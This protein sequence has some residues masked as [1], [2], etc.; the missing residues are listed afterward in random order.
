M[1]LKS[2]CQLKVLYKVKHKDNA[3]LIF[4]II[5]SAIELEMCLF[6]RVFVMKAFL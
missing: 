4:G 3:L 5:D 2:V 1:I 6:K